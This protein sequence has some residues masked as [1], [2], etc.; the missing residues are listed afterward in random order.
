[1]T[2]PRF[3]TIEYDVTDHVATIT[4]DRPERLNSFNQTMTEEIAQVWAEVRDDDDIRVAV[5]QA[6]GERAFCTG[7]DVEEGAWWAHLSPWNQEDP[8]MSLGP[9]HHRV[10]KPVI[11]AVHGMAA[12][13][14]MYFLN[15]SD[16]VICSE[17]ATFFDPHANAGIVS[18]LEPIGMLARGVNLGEVLRWALLGSDERMTAA[19]ALRAGIVSEV[20]PSDE[21]RER[22]QQ[23]AG[24]IAG[25]RPEGIQGTV[26]AIWE[27]LEM[28]PATAL[29]NGLSYTQIGNAG[30]GRSDSRTNKRPPRFR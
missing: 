25:R 3:K 2:D 22:A 5:L 7:I 12:G 11:S 30:S 16:I 4:L 20:V 27:S 17:D 19:T 8:G 18:S 24:E 23:L 28:V 6:N 1:M 21:L 10:W 15:Q 29:R 26:R 9:R 14:A 13:G